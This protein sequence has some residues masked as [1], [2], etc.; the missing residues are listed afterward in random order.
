MTDRT[1]DAVEQRAA[2]K[3]HELAI[4]QALFSALFH[5]HLTTPPDWYHSNTV[6]VQ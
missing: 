2:G 3:Q 1:R 5:R 4:G 6:L